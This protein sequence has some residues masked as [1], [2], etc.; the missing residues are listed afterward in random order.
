M[1]GKDK[2][3]IRRERT[4]KSQKSKRKLLLGPQWRL[5]VIK[6]RWFVF[7]CRRRRQRRTFE[8]AQYGPHTSL[9]CTG[10]MADA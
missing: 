6:C 5:R 3:S 2:E 9:F 1:E 4:R 8:I 10:K 7:L